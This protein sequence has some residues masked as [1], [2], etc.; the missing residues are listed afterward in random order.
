MTKLITTETLNKWSACE[1]GFKR[2][3]ELFP[4]GADLQTASAG[5]IADGRPDW[6]DWLWGACSR[7]DDYREQTVLVGGY[8]STLT[9]GYG[10]TLTGG[11]YSTLT[12]GGDSRLTGGDYSTLT[13]GHYSTLTG[14]NCSRLFFHYWDDWRYIGVAAN[15]GVNG[16]KPNTPY[17]CD[18]MGNI[19]EVTK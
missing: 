11:H 17:Q 19:V 2:F 1:D 4:E 9:G 13:G 6:S 12:G 10:S 18:N 8:G 15:V 3:C 14:G 5:L 7:D 16:I